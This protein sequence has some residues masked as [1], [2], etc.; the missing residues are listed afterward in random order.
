VDT[1]NI[2]LKEEPVQVTPVLAPRSFTTM[3]LTANQKRKDRREALSVFNVDVQIREIYN[4]QRR[5][6]GTA[7]AQSRVTAVAR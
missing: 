2:L 5:R 7:Q 6:R 3:R 1:F 4:N